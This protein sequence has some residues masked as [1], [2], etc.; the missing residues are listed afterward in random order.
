MDRSRT[1]RVR[2]SPLEFIFGT[3]MLLP[4]FEE[5]IEGQGARREGLVHAG[6]QGRLRRAD[7]RGDRRSAEAHLHGGRQARRGYPLRRQPG[8]DERLPGQ[9]HDGHGQG[10]RRRARQDGLQP[11]DGRQDAP[12]RR[13]GRFGARRNTRDLQGHCSCGSCGD[14]C[15]DGCCDDHGHG[16]GHGHCDCH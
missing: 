12:L 16:H 2:D 8:A 5:A 15:G 1:S 14:G 6:A 3:G 4:K 9:P 13:R 10:G 11:P 7:R